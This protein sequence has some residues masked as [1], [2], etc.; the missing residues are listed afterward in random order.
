[1]HLRSIPRASIPNSMHLILKAS[2]ACTTPTPACA[3]LLFLRPSC[4]LQERWHVQTWE[5]QSKFSNNRLHCLVQAPKIQRKVRIQSTVV[6]VC[7]SA[8]LMPRKM[9]FSWLARC[10]PVRVQN[11]RLRS[12]TKFPTHRHDEPASRVCLLFFVALLANSRRVAREKNTPFVNT[13][14]SLSFARSKCLMRATSPRG[15]LGTVWSKCA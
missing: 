9:T 13:V 6:Q 4:S 12:P 15:W 2:Q 10:T 14:F 5:E 8:P 7:V 1:M 3:R 11:L